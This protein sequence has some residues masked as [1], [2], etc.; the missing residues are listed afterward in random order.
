MPTNSY[1]AKPVHN[2]KYYKFFL[3]KFKKS[4][5]KKRSLAPVQGIRYNSRPSIY[6]Q[7]Q[8]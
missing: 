7:S 6:P 5:S 3:F 2:V 1:S 8:K 4:N